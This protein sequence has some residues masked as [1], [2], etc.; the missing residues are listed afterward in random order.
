MA[1]QLEQSSKQG[2]GTI[3]FLKAKGANRRNS[4]AGRSLEKQCDWPASCV[5]EWCAHFKNGKSVT[6]N[7]RRD[8]SE[9]RMPQSVSTMGATNSTGQPQNAKNA[10]CP[11]SCNITPLVVTNFSTTLSLQ[12]RHEFIITPQGW[13]ILGSATEEVKDYKI[14]QQSDVHCV[15]SS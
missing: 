3:Q 2:Q 4:S 13:N 1:T 14:C 11:H 6:W 5:A 8:H 10:I 9:F 12:I 7:G 15:L